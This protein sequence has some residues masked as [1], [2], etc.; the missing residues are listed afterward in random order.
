[1]F[2][3]ARLS[4]GWQLAPLPPPPPPLPPPPF[5]GVRNQSLKVNV[6]RMFSHDVT[7]VMLGDKEN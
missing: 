4:V 3:P 6:N 1:M 7:A 2:A 5:W